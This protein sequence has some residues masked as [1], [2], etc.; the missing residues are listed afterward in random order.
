M[1][2]KLEAKDLELRKL[3]ELLSQKEEETE[4]KNADNCDAN[5]DIDTEADKEVATEI[6]SPEVEV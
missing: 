1:Q 6:N 3:K 4:E 5:T 2:E